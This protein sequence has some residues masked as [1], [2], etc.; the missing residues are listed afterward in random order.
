MYEELKQIHQNT[1]VISSE[2]KANSRNDAITRY[3]ALAIT[4]TAVIVGVVMRVNYV[5]RMFSRGQGVNPQAMGM[6][7]I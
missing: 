6:S 3:I 7:V 5:K 1:M 2:E 4:I